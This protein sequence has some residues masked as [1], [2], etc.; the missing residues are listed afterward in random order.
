MEIPGSASRALLVSVAKDSERTSL[1]VVRRRTYT[2]VKASRRATT[3]F[4]ACRRALKCLQISC[5]ATT[6]THVESSTL[7]TTSR[8]RQLNLQELLFKM[9]E[10]RSEI[11]YFPT[12]ALLV[13][14]A[15]QS[16]PTTST[17]GNPP[18]QLPD[19]IV[20]LDSTRKTLGAANHA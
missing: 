18:A 15:A 10:A 11:I 4:D 20:N 5:R 7:A 2:L 1:D 3:C 14:L 12:T 19:H 13:R 9:L 17:M 16:R 6:Q 8:E